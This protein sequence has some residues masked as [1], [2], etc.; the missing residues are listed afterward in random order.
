MVST[1]LEPLKSLFCIHEVFKLSL[2]KAPWYLELLN[3]VGPWWSDDLWL[4]ERLTQCACPKSESRSAVHIIQWHTWPDGTESTDSE[5]HVSDFEESLVTIEFRSS[6]SVSFDSSVRISLRLLNVFQ[7]NYRVHKVHNVSWLT[8]RS[9][10]DVRNKL[11]TSRLSW[12][13]VS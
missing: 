13:T 11:Q 2:A 5:S 1:D 10:Y 12:R 3:T 7:S 6:I 4:E 8:K 9:T